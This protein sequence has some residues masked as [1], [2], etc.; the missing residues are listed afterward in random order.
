MSKKFF[1][2]FDKQYLGRVAV[3]VI[4]CVLAFGVIFYIGYHLVGKLSPGLELVDATLTTVTRKI[5]A[6]A[7][8][9]RD[10]EP[11]YSSTSAGSVVS[12]V[13]DG[14]RVSIYSKVADIYS[15]SSPEIENRLEEIDE[16]IKLLEKNRADNRSVQSTA[17][18]DSKIFEEVFDIRRLC[19]DGS[20]ADAL[21]AKKQLILEIKKRSILTGEIKNYDAQIAELQRE[22]NSLMA[23]LGALLSSVYAPRAGYYFSDYDGYGGTFSSDKIESMGYDDFMGMTETEESSTGTN[24]IG[25]MV[26]DYRWYIACEMSKSDAAYFMNVKKCQVTFSYSGEILTMDVHRVIP[27]TPGSRAVIVLRSEK[28][29]ADFDYT[30][31]QPVTISAAEYTGFE[32]PIEAIRV[33]GGY[34]GVFVLEEVTVEFRRINII[35]EDNGVV[36]CT[37][38]PESDGEASGSQIA[39]DEI[40]PWIALNDIVIVGGRDLYTGKIMD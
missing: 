15:H 31:M 33:I 2:R 28:M 6:D 35:Y 30:R 39:D 32:L 11:L 36:I 10:E 1:D 18:I 14:E 26:Y 19:E 4:S 7:Y 25:T 3:Y 34:E 38:K 23:N 24:C 40:Y 29:P 20:Y 16:Q 5:S 22:K 37:G 13:R 21:S 27:Q 12:S 8:I 9:M 17:G